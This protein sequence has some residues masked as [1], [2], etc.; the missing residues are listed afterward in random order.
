[1]TK[2]VL[3]L[4]TNQIESFEKW[5]TFRNEKP[6]AEY[7]AKNYEGSFKDDLGRT[8]YVDFDYHIHNEKNVEKKYIEFCD[9]QYSKN[10][11]VLSTNEFD[12]YTMSMNAWNA[13]A[14]FWG[15]WSFGL[16]E[17]PE[18]ARKN[19]LKKI[20]RHIGYA[21]QRAGLA[22]LQFLLEKIEE[23]KIKNMDAVEVE[24]LNHIKNRIREIQ[25]QLFI[26]SQ[27]MDAII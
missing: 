14:D 26:A 12:R 9:K 13:V 1:M 6:S 15:L 19:Y 17:N 18:R 11:L 20:K 10:V 5:F 7:I 23:K 4:K 2:Q 24:A 21:Y 8:V 25:L 27:R 16:K 22:G 3:N